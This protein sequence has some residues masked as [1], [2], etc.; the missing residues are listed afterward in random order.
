MAVTNEELKE[1]LNEL[2]TKSYSEGNSYE[3]ILE[4]CL[5]NEK[6]KNM[7]KRQGSVIYDTLAPI[8]M[9]LA[10]AYVKMD[11]MADQSYLLTAIGS[12]LDRKVYDYGLLREEA[13]Y[14]ERV[15][16]F[17]GYLVN[18][19]NENVYEYEEVTPG[20]GDYSQLQDE[21][22]F[23]GKHNGKYVSS[24]FIYVYKGAGN[25]SYNLVVAYEGAN[26]GSYLYNE[27]TRTY[28]YVGEGNGQYSVVA[29]YV[30][31]GNG[32]YDYE[33][34]VYALVGE[35][36][37]DYNEAYEY[38]GEGNGDYVRGDKMLVDIDVPIGSRFSIPTNSNL[39]FYFKETRSLYNEDDDLFEEY[40]ILECESAGTGGNAYFGT[41][42]ALTPTINLIE[43]SIGEIV[44]TARD[45]ETDDDLRE[46]ALDY[47]NN[48]AFGGNQS[49]YKKKLE[50]MNG[51]GAAKVFPA[52]IDENRVVM[53]FKASD[54]HVIL[55]AQ[56]SNIGTVVT[57]HSQYVYVGAGQ[58]H[59][60]FE[61]NE[62][63]GDLSGDYDI[64]ET[65]APIT[66]VDKLDFDGG[67]RIS[68]LND[69]FNPVS[70]LE[71]ARI[72]EEVD[73][74]DSS[75]QGMGIAPIG[76][77]VSIVTPSEDNVSTTLSA[78][79]KSG[80]VEEV[81]YHNIKRSIDSYI[82]SIR[83]DF[84]GDS[85]N[86]LQVVVSTII[87]R[88]RTECPNVTNVTNVELTSAKQ[89]SSQDIIVYQDTPYEQ[90]I[91]V[92]YTVI[93]NGTPVGD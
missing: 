16:I 54:D 51:V 73:P 37:G 3:E 57:L 19:F 6:L 22:E 66:I 90:L 64:I 42:V 9:E 77:Y 81:E 82:N 36:K 50:A 23:V 52:Y 87:A 43:S 61:N 67:V 21:Y 89:G 48:V 11:M 38:V 33:S 28:I 75:G 27:T 56:I 13:T 10:E 5:S 30:D 63:V 74:I 14:A 47:L 17:K 49:D 93:I 7:D 46:R 69:E 1:A 88:I 12:N 8:C 78:T 91:P 76:H 86:P 39:V 53:S 70:Q 4:R 18:N 15:G 32:E 58:G 79:I 71:L 34:N 84:G 85:S 80:A 40:N 62:Y 25:G 45:D 20:E 65:S 2:L 59:Y 26:K 31:V 92:S 29:F 24:Q 44:T 68:I 41:I 83:K 55:P 72:Q 60:R 35:H